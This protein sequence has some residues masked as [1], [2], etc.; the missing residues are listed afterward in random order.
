VP[1]VV[2]ELLGPLFAF[3]VAVVPV[4]D[5]K[6]LVCKVWRVAFWREKKARTHLMTKF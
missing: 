4:L 2:W 5:G 1:K 3:V 6:Y